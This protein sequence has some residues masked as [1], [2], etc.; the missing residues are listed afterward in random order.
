MSPCMKGFKSS[1]AV[2]EAAAYAATLPPC[3]KPPKAIFASSG[4]PANTSSSA[5]FRSCLTHTSISSRH[6]NSSSVGGLKDACLAGSFLAR[7]A[8]SS[9]GSSCSSYHS[10]PM[11]F[12]SWSDH[13]YHDD[14]LSGNVGTTIRTFPH[15]ESITSSNTGRYT[16]ASSSL[17]CSQ[18]RI[19]S[20]APCST[21]SSYR[22][23]RELTSGT[24]SKGS[25]R[26]SFSTPRRCS[27]SSSCFSLAA[28]S[29]SRFT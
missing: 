26:A 21:P 10:M 18:K 2:F 25:K 14:R 3:E 11:L 12:A 6:C 4:M 19:T 8:A 16:S 15:N 22:T 9:V 24:E 17:A 28:S 7:A 1:D 13:G 20:A 29:A 27:F 23:G 5:R